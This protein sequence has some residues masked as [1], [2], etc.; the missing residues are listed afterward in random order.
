MKWELS[1]FQDENLDN[2]EI[3]FKIFNINITN[4]EKDIKSIFLKIMSGG[5]RWFDFTVSRVRGDKFKVGKE[6]ERYFYF[7]LYI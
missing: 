1:C 2:L 7:Q 5:P 4:L 3:K 6:K